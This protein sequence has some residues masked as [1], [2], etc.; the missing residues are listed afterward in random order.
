MLPYQVKQHIESMADNFDTIL[1]HGVLSLEQLVIIWVLD[2][3]RLPITV[4]VFDTY[5][6]VRFSFWHQVRL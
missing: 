4:Y 6:I 3:G 5:N 1:N 2:H